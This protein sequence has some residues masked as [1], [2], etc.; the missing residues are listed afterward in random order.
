MAHD[1]MAAR[2]VARLE[3]AVRRKRG[4]TAGSDAIFVAL[5]P[6]DR[7]RVYEGFLDWDLGLLSIDADRLRYRGEQVA[8][9][10]PRPAVRSIEVGAAMP[11]WIPAPR[12]IVR[13]MAPAGEAALTLRPAGATRVGAI[14]PASRALAARLRAW[15]GAGDVA[16]EVVG[17]S[18]PAIGPVTSLRPA[19]A[20]APRDL[21]LLAGM[22]GVLAAGASFLLGLGFAL[23][24]D[25]FAAALL[26][27]VAVRW[28]AMTSRE[29]P[30]KATPEPASE[31]LAA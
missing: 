6:G 7:A 9:E 11:S 19:E 1:W 5:S 12:V 23:G 8:L 27:M 13:W 28:P 3:A 31:R 18:P 2:P 26:G 10:L 21:P 20:A 14:G 15:H 16:G 22:I 17:A 29:P 25:V 30:E 4:D 24:L